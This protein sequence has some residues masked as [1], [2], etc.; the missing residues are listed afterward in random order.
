MATLAKARPVSMKTVTREKRPMAANVAVFKGSLVA[1]K[2]GFYGPATGD[3]DEVLVG[4][5]FETMS[6]IGGAAGAKLVDVD[7]IRERLLALYENDAGA[8][9]TTAMRELPC[10]ALD[11]QTFTAFAPAKGAAAVLYDVTTEGVWV[12]LMFPTS[13]D[14]A[15]IPRLQPGTATLVAGTIT[16]AGKI[17]TANSRILLSMKDPGAGAIP[18]FAALDAPVASRNVGAGSFVINAIDNAKAT[19]AT[20]VCTVDYL[21]VG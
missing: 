5:A 17:I 7:F 1:A 16:V 8:P 6:N 19:I 21:I 15:G 10:S 20:A 3:P 9:L 2:A 12:E 18:A 11:D 13:A 4:K 14:D